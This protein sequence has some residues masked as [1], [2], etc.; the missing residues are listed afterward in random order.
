M[1]VD[2][3]DYLMFGVDVGADNFD[4]DKHQAEVE[5]APDRL[6]DVV[7]DGMSGE[8]CIAGKVLARTDAYRGEPDM[9]VI[10]PDDLSID[11]SALADIVSVAFGRQYSAGDF[12]LIMF[13]HFS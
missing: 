4:W 11:R 1:G 3:T 2:R 12:R 7:Y 6:F 13:S 8:Y 10:D 9:V 5:G